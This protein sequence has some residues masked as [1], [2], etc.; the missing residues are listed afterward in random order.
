[1]WSLNLA[2]TTVPA[3]FP[4]FAEGWNGKLDPTDLP[5]NAFSGKNF[6]PSKKYKGALEKVRVRHEDFL[7][8][9]SGS[10]DDRILSAAQASYNVSGTPA[11]DNVE[12]VFYFASNL[13][14][15]TSIT[16][17]QTP[18]TVAFWHTTKANARC[19]FG[20]RVESAVESITTTK[21]LIVSILVRRV[22]TYDANRHK[23]KATLYQSQPT[24]SSPS[25]VSG[26]TT[27]TYTINC[28]STNFQRADFYFLASSDDTYLMPGEYS[29]V[30]TDD[31]TTGAST[32]VHYEIA[33]AD[34]ASDP[35]GYGIITNDS[36]T[37]TRALA[38]VMVWQK[39]GTTSSSTAQDAAT[40]SANLA[41]NSYK[42]VDANQLFGSTLATTLKN[43]YNSRALYLSDGYSIYS[44]YDARIFPTIAGDIRWWEG[45]LLNS[46]YSYNPVAE[47][48]HEPKFM[49]KVNALIDYQNYLVVG[50]LGGLS[51]VDT[52]KNI[53]AYYSGIDLSPDVCMPDIEKRNSTVDYEW[54]T[55]Y[56]KDADVYPPIVTD[57]WKGGINP[58][59]IFAAVDDEIIWSGGTTAAT[60]GTPTTWSALATIQFGDSTDK[61]RKGCWYRKATARSRPT[62]SA[63]TACA[64][65]SLWPVMVCGLL[66]R[67]AKTCT[68]WMRVLAPNALMMTTSLASKSNLCSGMKRPSGCGL[69]QRNTSNIAIYLLVPMTPR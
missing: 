57:V 47:A 18:S 48:T 21:A 4:N 33:I 13:Y 27:P 68:S 42:Y 10:Q 58:G 16:G 34:G 12:G 61:I 66:R 30:I 29:V 8:L 38:E 55:T 17:K 2:K 53:A 51:I 1:V 9:G 7:A 26:L 32:T 28:D 50:G 11:F 35:N 63:H 37:T 5:P 39:K 19:K 40:L 60:A 46:L 22:G 69:A 3:I 14:S 6:L 65:M 67:T 56:T 36:A 52:A 23:L 44:L 59:R 25:A 64:R 62:I 43:I 41:L 54:L 31:S 24:S 49:G 45:I 20:I 15:L